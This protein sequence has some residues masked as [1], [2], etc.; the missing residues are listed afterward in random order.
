M[1]AV[2]FRPLPPLCPPLWVARIWLAAPLM[3]PATAEPIDRE[4]RPVPWPVAERIVAVSAAS[5][6]EAGMDSPND[7]SAAA[8][9]KQVL[10]NMELHSSV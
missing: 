10:A 5:C 7:S 3:L 9:G 2:L 1:R 8:I 6:A 4:A